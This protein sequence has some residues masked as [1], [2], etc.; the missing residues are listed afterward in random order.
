MLVEASSLVTRLCLVKLIGRLCLHISWQPFEA[1]PL[2]IGSQ[3]EPKNQLLW[4][5]HLA[6]FLLGT[7]RTKQP[8]DAECDPP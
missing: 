7:T 2:D 5:R 4:S 8:R 6:C 3:A 1:E